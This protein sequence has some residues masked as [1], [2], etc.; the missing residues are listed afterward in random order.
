MEC[1]CPKWHTNNRKRG[2]IFLIKER[3][4]N[5]FSE[6]EMF[7]FLGCNSEGYTFLKVLVKFLMNAYSKQI[8]YKT[9]RV[10]KKAW[11]T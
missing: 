11:F 5:D 1:D 8:V 4:K 9:K 2:F 6:I 10:T 7:S 3:S